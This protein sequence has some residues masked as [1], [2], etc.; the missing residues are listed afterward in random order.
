MKEKRKKKSI[1]IL[2]TEETKS[3]LDNALEKYGHG[4]VSRVGEIGIKK[5][6]TEIDEKGIQF[7][8][9]NQYETLH[10]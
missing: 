9:E 1:N 5:V 7:I 2:V 4:I 6:L 10:L 3:R 8:Y